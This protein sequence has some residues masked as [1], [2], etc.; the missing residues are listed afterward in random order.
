M[1][2][3]NIDLM[4]LRPT[5]RNMRTSDGRIAKHLDRLLASDSFIEDMIVV[6]WQIGLGG[7]LD[8]MPIFLEIAKDGRKALSP[9]K[10]N[11]NWLEEEDYLIIIKESW[12]NFNEASRVLATIQFDWNLARVKKISSLGPREKK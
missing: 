5:W 4:K 7:E 10:F 8:H 1:S 12:V 11:T 3:Y 6:K 9:L 2:L